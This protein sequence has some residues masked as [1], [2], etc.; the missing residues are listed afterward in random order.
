MNAT[1]EEIDAALGG[2]VHELLE[3]SHD[4]DIDIE[5]LLE[6]HDLGIDEEMVNRAFGCHEAERDRADGESGQNVPTKLPEFCEEQLLDDYGLSAAER[7]VVDDAAKRLGRRT[8]HFTKAFMASGADLSLVR[9]TL[10]K[11]RS[12][13]WS[14]WIENETDLEYKQVIRIINAYERAQPVVDKYFGGVLGDEWQRISLT[15]FYR[16]AKLKPDQIKQLIELARSGQKVRPKTINDLFGSTESSAKSDGPVTPEEE[17]FEQIGTHDETRQFDDATDPIVG[18][19]SYFR[20]QGFDCLVRAS[21]NPFEG[22]FAVLF[23]RGEETPV[24]DWNECGRV[25][26][27]SDVKT[28][29]ERA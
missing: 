20:S 10:A 24:S 21:D 18:L 9:D 4:D 17:A 14:E 5:V 29:I 26:P 23:Y 22:P 25:R 15:A 8:K 6:E 19:V 11:A 3:E 7:S 12:G 28:L 16:F 27:A 2:A 13:A 1:T